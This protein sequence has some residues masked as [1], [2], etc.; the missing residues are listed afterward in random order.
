MYIDIIRAKDIESYCA[1]N[2]TRIVDLEVH[3]NMS[4][5]TFLML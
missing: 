2:N 3:P 4:N 1:C 5:L